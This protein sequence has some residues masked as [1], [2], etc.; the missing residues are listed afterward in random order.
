MHRELILGLSPFFLIAFALFAALFRFFPNIDVAASSLF[1]REN[2]S[3][4]LENS[5][6]G[7]A[8][9]YGVD[10]AATILT[11]FFIFYLI[12]SFIKRKPNFLGLPRILVIYLALAYIIGPGIVVNELLKD[13]IGR[14]RPFQ[15][16]YFMGKADFSPAFK[17][18][19]FGGKYASFVSGHA[20]F[21]FYWL[22]LA[23][24]MKNRA[25]RR[26]YLSA[27]ICLGAGIGLV[28]IMQGKHFLSDVVFSF[29]F[30]YM[31]AAILWFIIEKVCRK[32][33]AE[34]GPFG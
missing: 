30:I 4:L 13:K 31:S 26:K 11:L 19:E 3:F 29:F 22:S 5:P 25:N 28:R 21:G 7:F 17:V 9:Y 6:V 1:F 12:F 10:A 18:T 20:A 14:A 8:V 27:G 33:L 34:S 15:T 2:S 23:F 16:S 24:P 32:E